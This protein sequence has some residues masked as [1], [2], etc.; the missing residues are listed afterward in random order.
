MKILAIRG[1]NLAS[2]AGEFEVDF[3]QEPLK[4]AGLFA[5][6]GPTGAGKSTL[7]D[8]LCMAL[9]ESTPRLLNA[10]NKLLPDVGDNIVTQ[11]DARNLLRRGTAEGHAEV[12]FVG[13]D[14]ISYRAR[15]SVRRARSKAEGSLQKTGMTLKALS[16]LQPI[17]GTNKEVLAEIV[18]RIGLSFDQFTRAVLLAQNEFSAFLKADDN[19]RGELLETLTGSTIYSTLSQRAYA[20]AK[21]EQLELQR[22]NDR[23]ADQKPL[24]DEARSQLEQDS[25]AANV[26][27]AALD[28]RQALLDVQLRWHRDDDKFRQGEELAQVQLQ[29][30][31]AEQAAAATRRAILHRVNSVQE[32]RPLVAEVDRL[33]RTIALDNSAIIDCQARLANADQIRQQADAALETAQRTLHDAERAQISAA[34]ALDQAKAL[35]ARID[36]LLPAHRQAQQ[37]K[38]D[39]DK[40]VTLTQQNRQDKQTELDTARQKQ[41]VTEQWLMQHAPLQMLSENW[42]RWDVL[43]KQSC[44]SRNELVHYEGILAGIAKNEAKQSKLLNAAASAVAAAGG[45]LEEADNLRQQAARHHASIDITGLQARKQSVDMRRDQLGSAEQLWRTLAEQQMRQQALEEQSRDS[46]QAVAQADAALMQVSQKAPALSAALMQAERS[47]K[48]AE[49]ACGASVETLRAALEDDVP[50]PV[51][52]ATRHPYTIDNPQLHAMLASLQAEVASCR[53]KTQLAQQQQA[54]HDAEAASHRRQLDVIAQEQQQLQGTIQRQYQDWQAHPLAAELATIEATEQAD[55][56]AS[57]RAI[58]QTQLYGINQMEVAWH[59]AVYAKDTA[60]VAFDRTT[61]D[62]NAKKD[63]ASTAQAALAKT[64]AEQQA[65]AEQLAQSRHRLSNSMDQLDTAF[66]ASDDAGNGHVDGQIDWRT[67]WQADPEAFYAQCAQNARQWQAQRITRDE[68]MQRIATLTLELNGLL[69]MQGRVDADQQRANSAFTASDATLKAMKAQRHTLFSGQ[70]VQQ[71]EAQLANA[72]AA[73]KALLLQHTQSS[74]DSKQAHTRSSEA[75]EQAKAQ[76]ASHG[77]E[78]GVS[79]KHLADWIDRYTSDDSEALAAVQLD[80]LLA[81]PADWIAGERNHLYAI[82]AAVQQ[83]ATVLQERSNQRQAHQE[84][85]P[86]QDDNI[87]AAQGE[88][89]AIATQYEAEISVHPIDAFQ[90]ALDILSVERQSAQAKATEL[91]LALAQD[92]ARHVHAADMLVTFARQE[93][94]HRLWA[95]LNDL[96]GAADGKKFRNYAQQTTLD[97]LLGYANRHLNEL[98]RRYRLQRISD[99]L[100]L[101]VVDQDMGDELRSVHSLSGGESFLVSLALALGLASLSSNRVRVESLFIDEGFGSLDAD[102]LRVA[103]DALDGLQSM[104]R[105]VGVISHVQE[106]TERIATKILVQR[107]SGGRSVV[108]TG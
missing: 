29:Q 69:D 52:G 99:T 96:I 41:Q 63:A 27:V 105:K 15:W 4:S 74:N 39:V 24:T 108:T 93:S 32:A 47:L 43:F 38:A 42:Q 106:M 103:M 5:I 55:W 25:S 61:L 16:D 107:T 22:I 75:L 14:G 9:Y 82:D 46:R 104:G 13:N 7:L 97:V 60:Q 91:Q 6:S 64:R 30:R 102:T 79:S 19:E 10:G 95:Q 66:S 48:S 80:A 2:L 40:A 73:A 83:A 45:A 1:K 37:A 84:R 92:K 56:L 65:T 100:A 17:G 76:L 90:Q 11:Q 50:C 62:Y 51:C 28:V 57:Q 44:T 49:A 86:Q 54:T 81:H 31:Q 67:D 98:S 26:I 18:K 78:A 8:A 70:L 71:I 59:A 85:R 77:S 89:G 20:R 33:A 94:T 34:P 68:D 58:V 12:D 53:Q 35:D 72:I 23:L 36:T 3:E 101:M 88:A 21:Q 87:G